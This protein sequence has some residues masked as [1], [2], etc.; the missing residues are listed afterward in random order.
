MTRPPDFGFDDEA[1]LLRDA[2]VR[3][4]NKECP[5]DALHRLVA[6]DASHARATACVWDQAL[7]RKMI[8]LGWT[9]VAV[10]TAVGGF[11][12]NLAAIAGLAE[13]VG[14]AAIPSPLI[15]TLC[16]TYVLAACDSDA[17]RALLRRIV[18]GAAVSLAISD[19]HGATWTTDIFNSSEALTGTASFVQDA[20]KAEAFVVLAG[21]SFYIVDANATGVT[22]TPDAIIDLTRDQATLHCKN[23]PAVL[24]GPAAS[25]IRAAEPALLVI[26]A[27]DM[28]GAAEW[29]LQTT[30]EYAR[31]RVQFDRPIGFFQAVKHPLVDMM[32]AIDAA[33]TLLYD[34]ACAFDH[35]PD[36]AEVRAR[37]AKSAASDAAV[38]C[39]GRS[40]Q[41]HGG[42]GFTWEC[43]VQIYFKRQMHNAA[44]LG[45]GAQQRARLA[46]LLIGPIGT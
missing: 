44:L 3:L 24:A 26:L 39:S 46:D 27:A 31:T 13:T 29:Q 9:A 28:V 12:M 42:I 4:F 2:A 14:R 40:V 19:R 45:D 33:R 5:P 34:A 16:A 15:A 43:S 10:P 17:A 1:Q 7:W 30:A 23:C 6:A 37:M 32:L 8:D 21:D 25:A 18:D 36:M 38:F 11:G 20:R 22:I 35:E 41:L